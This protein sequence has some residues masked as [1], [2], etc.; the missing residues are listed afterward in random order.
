MFENQLAFYYYSHSV[1]FDAANKH[2]IVG[3]VE[4]GV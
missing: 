3:I 2:G 1:K 4:K